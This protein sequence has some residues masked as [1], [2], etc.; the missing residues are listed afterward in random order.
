MRSRVGIRLR[1][2]TGRRLSP[3]VDRRHP[4]LLALSMEVNVLPSLSALQSRLGA[5]DFEL[6]KIVVLL[7]SVLAFNMDVN[8]LPSLARLQA[9]LG[10]SDAEL[11]T[12]H[13]PLIAHRP[14]LTTHCSRGCRR[15][16][17]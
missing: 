3:C 17:G 8:V 12:H 5:T 13:S 11:T 10:L 7:P 14:P 1:P 6:K 16:S 15:A 2:L 4:A 9:R